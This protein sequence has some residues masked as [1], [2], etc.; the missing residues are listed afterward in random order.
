MALWSKAQQ[1]PNGGFDHIQSIYNE[2]FPVEV[3]HFLAPWIEAQ[4]W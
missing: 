3:R 2:N 4:N 1:L